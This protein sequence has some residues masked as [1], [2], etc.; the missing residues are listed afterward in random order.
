MASSEQYQLKLTALKLAFADFSHSLEIKVDGYPDDVLDLIRNGQVQKF[1]VCLDLLWKTIK[2]FLYETD[3][4]EANSPKQAI[5]EFFKAGY[6]A[7]GEFL[8]FLIMV[9]DRN[10]LSHVYRSEAFLVIHSRLAEHQERMRG[11]IEKIS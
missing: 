1:E 5:R 10:L 7:E 8:G 6:W 9:D 3:G 2:I 11:I 4:V